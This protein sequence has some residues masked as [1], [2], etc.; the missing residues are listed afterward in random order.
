LRS[1]LIVE[2]TNLNGFPVQF[3]HGPGPAEA[4]R[5]FVETHPEFHADLSCEKFFLTFNH[6]GYLRRASS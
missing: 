2:D 1:A 4:V 3:R 6:G 5:K